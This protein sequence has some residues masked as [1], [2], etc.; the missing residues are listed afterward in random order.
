MERIQESA[1]KIIFMFGYPQEAL[2]DICNL[3]QILEKENTVQRRRDLRKIATST[4][5]RNALFT[6]KQIWQI[7]FV[8]SNNCYTFKIQCVTRS[9]DDWG[10]C[11]NVIANGFETYQDAL[12]FLIDNKIRY[13]INCEE[14]THFNQIL[15]SKELDKDHLPDYIKYKYLF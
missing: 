4:K 8:H 10:T 6:K 12:K 5:K 3:L 15:F 14:N 13:C 11:F 2:Q 9:Y 7:D 1:Q